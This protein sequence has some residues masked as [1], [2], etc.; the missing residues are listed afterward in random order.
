MSKVYQVITDRI[1]GLL[2]KGTVPWRRPWGGPSSWPKNLVSG[3]RYRG[4]NVFLLSSA[5]YESPYWV[6]F[7]QA[8]ER[9]GHVK[10]GEKGYPVIFWNWIE[11]EDP[12]TGRVQRIPFLKYYTA[13]NAVQTEGVEFPPVP[14]PRGDFE[15]IAACEGIVSGMPRSPTIEHRESRAF[16]RPSTDTVNMPRP[17]MFIGPEPYYATLYHEL[18]HATGHSSR[19]NRLGATEA[20]AFGS[21][22]YSREELVAEMGAAFICW[23]C[24][25]DSATIENSAA[26]VAG[27][28]R[29]LRSDHRLVVT[30]AAQA[31]KAADYIL[32]TTF[33]TDET[34]G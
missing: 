13:F 30:A 10:K 17:S 2:E 26:Y 31:Q 21:A 18:T 29:R 14:K 25:I 16:Y 28:L 33:D 6:T 22:D 1:I 11:R 32:G 5:G 15:P 4:V 24:G 19:L 8:K 7:R 12:E 9:G 27:W 20:V 23:H 34:D 3:K